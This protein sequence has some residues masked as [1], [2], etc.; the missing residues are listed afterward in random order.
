MSIV[1]ED[2]H[3]T[4]GSPPVNRLTCPVR[5]VVVA[6]DG[7]SVRLAGACLRA[8]PHNSAITSSHTLSY[9]LS[10]FVVRVRGSLQTLVNVFTYV[11]WAFAYRNCWRSNQRGQQQGGQ[12]RAIR[13][14]GHHAMSGIR[15]TECYA[16]SPDMA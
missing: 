11:L 15:R 8:G 3:K 10:G 5:K 14:E 12:Y 6:P 4:Y 16:T 9:L 1:V 2:Y 13:S 7:L